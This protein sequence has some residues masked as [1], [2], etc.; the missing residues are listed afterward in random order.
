MSKLFEPLKIK[1]I[2]FKNRIAVSPMCQ[3]SAENGYANDWHLVHLGSRAVGGAGLIIVEATAVSPEGRISPGDMGLWEE[4]QIAP[5]KRI[6][7]FIHA[8]GAVAGIQIAH[9]GRK[10]SHSAPWKGGVQLD[11][12]NNGWTCVAPSPIPFSEN[13]T[14]PVELDKQGI[15]KI[16]HDFKRTASFAVKAGFKVLEI[17]AAHG[18]LIHEF[19]SP[20]T[21]HRQDKYGGSLENRSRLLLEVTRAVQTEWPAELPLFVRLSGTDWYEGGWDI[22]QTVQLAGK[23]K[24]AGVDLIDCSSGGNIAAQ[25]IQLG[26]GYQV[27]FSEAVRKTGILTGTVG[28]I[29]TAQQAEEILQNDKADLILL[30][31][32]LLR[33]PYFP[34]RAAKE[35]DVKVDW[36]VQY[37]RAK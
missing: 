2:T 20:L 25:K 17:H 7:D 37:L 23:L 27:P 19:L 16:I 36:P 8:N 33:D 29:T 9:A 14:P 22:G 5:L 13:E 30:G 28:L 6:V 1:E 11:S 32:E 10:A 4:G 12:A 21:N 15:E 18:Y 35:L 24:D 3:Y 34:L 31:R 26:P